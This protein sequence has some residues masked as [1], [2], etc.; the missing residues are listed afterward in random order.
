MLLLD[1]PTNHLDLDTI[2]W[3][4][5]WLKGYRGAVLVVSHD[6]AFLDATCPETLELRAPK[7][8]RVYPLRYSDYAV[9]READLERERALVEKQQA[10]IEKTK[11]FIRKNTAGQKA[12]QAQSRR[13]TLDRLEKLEQPEDVWA[14][15]EKVAFRFAPAARSGDIVLDAKA[16]AAERAA[17]AR[18]SAA[19]TC[20]LRRGE[21]IGI[22]GPNGAGQ[23][24]RCSGAARRPR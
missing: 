24:E 4:E 20:S 17:A 22:V 2:A 12:N 9:Q 3:L 6:R 11:E 15:A 16:L 1:E 23:V 7:G 5:S 21:R 18:S 14:V 19:S 10:Y 8:L 13:K